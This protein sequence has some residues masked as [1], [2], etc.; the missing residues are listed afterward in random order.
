MKN[1]AR[2]LF[3]LTTT[4]EGWELDG[5]GAWGQVRSPAGSWLE[6]IELPAGVRPGAIEIDGQLYDHDSP[7]GLL[8]GNNGRLVSSREDLQ[9]RFYVIPASWRNEL[10][11]FDVNNDGVVSPIDVLLTISLLNEQGSGPL[12]RPTITG[13]HPTH[14]YDVSDDE[15]VSPIDALLVISYLNQQNGSGEGEM[16]VSGY[17]GPVRSLRNWD[18]EPER[19]NDLALEAFLEESTDWGLDG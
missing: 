5:Q 2:R 18:D 3:A 13:P 14:F 17:P 11:P 4:G 19:V 15:F 9:T 10:N 1:L 8:I 12:E 16:A 7:D 6:H